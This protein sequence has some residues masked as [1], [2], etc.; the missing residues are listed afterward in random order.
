MIPTEVYELAA[1]LAAFER[2]EIE[3]SDDDIT[4]AFWLIS[5]LNQN[6]IILIKGR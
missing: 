4:K 1:A 5:R 6:A 3:P 2:D